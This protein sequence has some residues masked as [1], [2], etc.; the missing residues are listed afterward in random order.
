VTVAGVCG[1]IR[2]APVSWLNE[3]AK[4]IKVL[5]TQKKDIP[6]NL[7]R[8]CPQCSEILYHRELDRNLWVCGACGHH[9]PFTT[10]QYLELLFDEGTGARRT[11]ASPARTPSTSATRS[12][13]ATA[14]APP[15]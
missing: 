13:I 4:G 5:S 1:I 3:A 7:W 14:S 11:A 10:E 9:L 12:A 8:K 15:G 2:E 6:D